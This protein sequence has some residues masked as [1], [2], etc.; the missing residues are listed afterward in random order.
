MSEL[1]VREL[2]TRGFCLDI[3]LNS[4]GEQVEDVEKF[5]YVGASSRQELRGGS[6][7]IR[8]KMQKVHVQSAFQRLKKVWSARGIGRTKIRL[9]KTFI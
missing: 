4:N 1:H 6:R 5:V 2:S 9:F 3:T 8:H 7:D